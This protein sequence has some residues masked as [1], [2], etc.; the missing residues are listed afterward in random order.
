MT[1]KM[2]SKWIFNKR[3]FL[4]HFRDKVTVMRVS[5]FQD[6]RGISHKLSCFFNILVKCLF[7]CRH[8]TYLTFPRK[9]NQLR[10]VFWF[11]NCLR[12]LSSFQDQRFMWRSCFS[13]VV[14]L[15]CICQAIKCALLN[16]MTINLLD[17][18]DHFCPF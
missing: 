18:P 2:F 9:S 17:I 12:L 6:C 14:I 1:R 5:F 15:I 4:F 16:C 8:S 7:D 3:M 11:N 13:D 10:T